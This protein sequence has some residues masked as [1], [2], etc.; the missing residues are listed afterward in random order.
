MDGGLLD[1]VSS[2]EVRC[3]GECHKDYRVLELCKGI[4]CKQEPAVAT[5]EEIRRDQKC[6]YKLVGRCRD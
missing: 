5:A 4:L 3:C 6:C 1:D 2:T